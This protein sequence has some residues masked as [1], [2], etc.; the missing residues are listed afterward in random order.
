MR[1]GFYIEN[2]QSAKEGGSFTFQM[3]L[4]DAL[5]R[6]DT[7]NEIY[8]YYNAKEDLF[9]NAG[10]VKFVNIKPTFSDKFKQFFVSKKRKRNSFLNQFIQK[11]KIEFMYFISAVKDT[12]KIP[13]ALI[14]WDLGHRKHTYFPEVSVTGWNFNQRENRYKD[15]I[16]K[17]SYTIIGTNAGREQ[18]HQYY[19]Y[20]LDRIVLNPM[21]TPSYVYEIKED[22][23]ILEKY[24]LQPQKYLFYP[25]QFWPHKNHIRLLKAMKTLK[26]KG[27]KLVLT[28]SDKGN[29]KYIKE[30]V[31][32][33]DLENDVFFLGFVKIEEMTALYK[34]AYALV[35]ASVMGPDNIPPLEALALGCPAVVSEYD[36][37]QD[38]L[39][40]CA[41]YFNPF[42]ENELIEQIEKLQ[43]VEL[44]NSLIEKGKVLAKERHID[45]YAQKLMTLADDFSKIRECW[46]S[47]ETY[48]HL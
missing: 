26:N 22:C 42:D 5:K 48:V 8:F 10:N 46:S 1:I 28:G 3:S 47:S 14:V 21:P 27:F 33:Y 39:K 20:D 12:V 44:K 43:S 16:P 7:S 30:K 4:I 29:L 18:V 37:A 25:A 9:E 35:F 31:K 32:E 19:S 23:S 38:Q 45:N 11:D 40:D 24:N 34:N 41:L 13:Y 6:I 17:A 15:I 36:G 2:I